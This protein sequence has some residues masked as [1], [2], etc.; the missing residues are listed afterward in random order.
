MTASPAR[1][2]MGIFVWTSKFA[3]ATGPPLDHRWTTV[4]PVSGEGPRAFTLAWRH[5]GSKMPGYDYTLLS[6]AADSGHGTFNIYAVV[7]EC[8]VPRPTR[9]TGAAQK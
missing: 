3:S 8:S 7:A 4:A 6:A 5:S 9:G 1:H 2:S